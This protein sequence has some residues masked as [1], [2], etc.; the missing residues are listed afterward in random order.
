MRHFPNGPIMAPPLMAP[1]RCC[2]QQSAGKIYT[3]Y[4][5]VGSSTTSTCIASKL[6]RS[7]SVMSSQRTA[8]YSPNHEMKDIVL[9]DCEV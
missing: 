3:T 6:N 5:N 7:T 4:T 8:S 2:H 1:R 9:S